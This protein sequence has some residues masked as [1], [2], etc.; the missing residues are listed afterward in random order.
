M[1]THL[2]LTVILIVVIFAAFHIIN[3]NNN[4]LRE[5]SNSISMFKTAFTGTIPSPEIDS[6]TFKKLLPFFKIKKDEFDPVGILSYIP[7]DSPEKPKGNAF[8]CYF[9]QINDS[10]DNLRVRMQIENRDWLFVKKCIFLIDGNVYEYNPK[11]FELNGGNPGMVCEWFDDSVCESNVGIIKALSKAK[12][13]KVK[14]I[15]R[16]T[17]KIIEISREQIESINNTLTLYSAMRGAI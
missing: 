6:I 2:K 11:N 14:L 5:S 17:H 7:K 3:K 1:K 4:S 16:H 10:V 13:A 8:Y 12:E 15:G 9:E